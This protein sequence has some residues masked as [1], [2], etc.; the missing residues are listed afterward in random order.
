MIFTLPSQSYKRH[1]LEA[2]AN[3]GTAN[4]L[5]FFYNE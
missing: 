5:G 3:A 4:S 1:V 2:I